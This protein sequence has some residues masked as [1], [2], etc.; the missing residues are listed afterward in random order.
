MYNVHLGLTGKPIVD[1]LLVL[2]KLFSQ[3][4]TA[5]AVR[6]KID[7]KSAISFQRSH[8]SKISD[9]RGPPTNHFCTVS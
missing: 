7:G 4:V 1:F 9:T 8:R 5:E 3:G 6:A 2:I